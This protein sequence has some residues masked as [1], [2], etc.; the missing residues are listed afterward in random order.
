MNTP[1]NQFQQSGERGYNQDRAAKDD[2]QLAKDAGFAASRRGGAL[3]D[4]Y[5]SELEKIVAA[6]K[7]RSR[8]DHEVWGWL[9]DIED[10]DARL[11]WSGT[12]AAA[13]TTLCVNS[14]HEKN[15]RDVALYIGCA[16]GQPDKE[17]RWKVGL[18]GTDRLAELKA[19]FCLDAD[20]VLKLHYTTE[21]KELTADAIRASAATDPMLLPSNKPPEPWTDVWRHAGVDGWAR[22]SLVNRPASRDAVKKAMAVG[23][24]KP[25]NMHTVTDA[26]T[27]LER[28]AW[29]INIDVF[30]IAERMPP[31]PEEPPAW[32]RNLLAKYDGVLP[33]WR[34]TKIIEE[35]DEAHD[36]FAALDKLTSWEMDIAMAREMIACGNRFYVPHHL[37]YRGRI[38]ATPLLSYQRGDHIRGLFCFAD[39]VPI[40]EHGLVELKVYVA[41]KAEADRRT[42]RS[43]NLKER[44]AWVDQHLDEFR[45]V[46]EAVLNGNIPAIP[47]AVGDPCQ[48]MAACVELTKADDNP[49][50]MTSLPVGFDATCSAL[51]H[52]TALTGSPEG[53]W[54]NLAE[55]DKAEDLYTMVAEKADALLTERYWVNTKVINAKGEDEYD[56]ETFATKAEADDFI[57][58]AGSKNSVEV[59]RDGHLDIKIGRDLAKQPVS[60]FFYGSTRFGMVKQVHEAL[61]E[62][63]KKEGARRFMREEARLIAAALYDAVED[64]VP[65]ATAVRDF[66][67][68]LAELYFDAGKLMQWTALN[69]CMPVIN[70]GKDTV[71]ATYNGRLAGRRKRVK[72]AVEAA[73]KPKSTA[74]ELAK[75]K[76]KAKRSVIQCAP[77]NLVHSLDGALAARVVVSAAREDHAYLSGIPLAAV[78][79]CFVAPAP[80]AGR[81]RDTLQHEMFSL[82]NPNNLLQR[83]YETAV[84]DL[85]GVE[86]PKPPPLG[87]FGVSGVKHN[88]NAFKS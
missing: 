88:F 46:G 8:P 81:L 80:R 29:S 73:T 16:L 56:L 72:L 1:G 54:V 24:G 42:G 6:D 39:P 67:S 38:L 58:T 4:C 23:R 86:I 77:A 68:E 27:A 3:F 84:D 13:S 14:E 55:S 25:G 74:K 18:W 44:V 7:A 57:A 49:D 52:L 35:N 43:L 75:A 45:S 32:L 12:T 30:N 48:Y 20:D 17:R 26:I 87:S 62:R 50:F 22:S 41:G 40:G 60:T 15:S 61:K 5:L 66:M 37:D 21:V 76:R 51:Q 9:K 59:V 64:A 11:L 31:T 19:L 71:T 78:H 28:V 34:K 33:D 2:E 83:I 36:F 10:R 65:A 47:N 63:T 70:L 69:G 85:P 53:R 79:D 82:Y